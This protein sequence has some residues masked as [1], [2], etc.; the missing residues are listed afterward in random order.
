MTEILAAIG[1]TLGGIWAFFTLII[2]FFLEEDLVDSMYLS[3]C[4]TILIGVAG[5]IVAGICYLWIQVIV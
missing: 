2:F 5:S 1:A 3:F 4:L